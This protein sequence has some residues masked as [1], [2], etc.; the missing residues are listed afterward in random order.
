LPHRN[1]KNEE[2]ER[3]EGNEG[4]EGQISN[5]ST[6]NTGVIYCIINLFKF[7]QMIKKVFYLALTLIVLSVASMNAQVR[8]G[9][10]MDPVKGAVLD[11]NNPTTGYRGGLLLPKVSLTTLS[12][13]TDI[14]ANPTSDDIKNLEGLIVYNTNPE[15]GVGI[16]IWNGSNEWKLIWKKS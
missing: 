12:A 14:V 13:I 10:L 1:K 5:I 9:G 11:L 4:N 6:P 2:N 3:N 8:I 7:Y 16:Y 15:K